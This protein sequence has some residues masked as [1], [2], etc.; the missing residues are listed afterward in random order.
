MS[1]FA[2]LALD[3]LSVFAQPLL[4]ASEAGVLHSSGPWRPS[5]WAKPAL[6]AITVPGTAPASPGIVIDP[7]LGPAPAAPAFVGKPT[8]L[9]FDAVF[10]VEHARHLRRT[11]H[12]IQTGPNSAVGSI[13]DHAYL[14]PARV[15]LEIGMSDAMASYSSNLWTSDPSKSVSAYQTLVS[16]M[17][18]RTLVTLT[19]RLQTYKNMLVESIVPSDSHK[20]RHGLRALVTLGEIFLAQVPSTP[21]ADGTSAANANPAAKHEVGGQISGAFGTVSARPQ[22]T[23]S[24]PSGT[25]QPVPPSDALQQQ[26]NITA[27]PTVS[28]NFPVVPGAGNWSG[29]NVSSLGGLLG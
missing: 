18:A 27:T 9:V 12:P 1:N 29:S 24:T 25:V 20:T 2:F 5:E 13:T 17:S 11:E 19:T 3:T 7:I 21:G 16:L 10:K 15:T 28:R 26:H 22:I 23:E 14:L 6:T 4:A 8:V